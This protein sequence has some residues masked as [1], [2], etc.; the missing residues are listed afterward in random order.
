MY[1]SSSVSIISKKFNVQSIRRQ[2]TA[3][4]IIQEPN[5]EM[6]MITLSSFT[7]QLIS[8]SLDGVMPQMTHEDSFFFNCI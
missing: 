4:E 8:L 5:F 2:K 3:I 1:I 7:L 6:R